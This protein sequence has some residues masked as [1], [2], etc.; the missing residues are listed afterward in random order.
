MTIGWGIVGLG[1]WMDRFATPAIRQA[2]DTKLVGVVS[3]D[4]VR[5][6]K[7]AAYHGAE[8]AYDRLEALLDNP[9]VDAI[10]VGTPNNLH[11]EAVIAA[12]ER[13]KHSICSIAMAVSEED[14]I[15]MVEACRRHKVRLG[16]DFQTRYHP[17]FRALRQVIHDGTIGEVVT[18]RCLMSLPWEG[19][20][21]GGQVWT[22]PAIGAFAGEFDQSWKKDMSMR[23]AGAMSGAGM[24]GIDML[25]FLLGR[26]VEQVFAVADVA[27][28]A[29]TQETVVQAVLTFQ[30]GILASFETTSHTPF[31]DN[32][33]TVSGTKGRASS[34]GLRPWDSDGR[35][36][37][38]TERGHVS[39]EFH[40][41]NMFVDQIEAFNRN[42]LDGTEPN[43]SGV[44]G[45]RERQ[46]T[47]AIRESSLK[48]APVKIAL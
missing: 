44:D 6:E 27:T 22:V 41:H 7:F 2:K 21:R 42:I 28:A 39:R 40:R 3:R 16:V 31:S 30:G 19:G 4:K 36:D 32:T 10:F 35:L 43:A 25:R 33:T 24:F 45:W 15:A 8:H 5:A 38:W 34:Y 46:I 14:C 29:R 20:Q 1:G 26:D 47:L 9:E 13:G 11:A 48:N 12:A 37:V 23:G 18:A 17:G